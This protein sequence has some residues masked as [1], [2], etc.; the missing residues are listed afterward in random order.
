[1]TSKA[2]LKHLLA[3]FLLLSFAASVRA[4]A[5]RADVVVIAHPSVPVDS[6]SV[7][8][9]RAFFGMRLSRWSGGQP[10]RVYVLADNHPLHARFC[11]QYL[12]AYPHMMRRAW[13]KLVF[14]GTGQAPTEV[15]DLE[16]MLR[17][18]AETPGALGYAPSALLN[19]EVEVIHVRED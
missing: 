4:E 5:P 13:S 3:I 15:A 19:G 10:V 18:V 17:R 6:V 12:R 2:I 8:A 16:E 9:L 1:M 11:K 7:S 14:S